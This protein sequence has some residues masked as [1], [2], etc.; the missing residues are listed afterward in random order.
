M[1]H[2]RTLTKYDIRDG[3]YCIITIDDNN[4]QKSYYAPSFFVLCELFL[5]L[6]WNLY[7]ENTNN[8]YF[9]MYIDWEWKD[10]TGATAMLIL[11]SLSTDA[12]TKNDRK[13]E[14]IKAKL[15]YDGKIKTL[16]WALPLI[17]IEFI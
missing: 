9:C 14:K 8:F 2:V 1:K 16:V 3:D 4:K 11:N 17:S 13:A 5:I 15:I 10:V 12:S 6:S 7:I